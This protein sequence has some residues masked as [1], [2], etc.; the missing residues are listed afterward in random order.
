MLS[1]KAVAVLT[2]VI[3]AGVFA[4]SAGAS[5]VRITPVIKGAGTVYRVTGT[6]QNP[7]FTEM[8]TNT[9]T[10][11]RVT[12]NDC[13]QLVVSN[14]F[15]SQIQATI[16]AVPLG[17]PANHWFFVPGWFPGT[18]H[19]VTPENY[20]TFQAPFLG[21]QSF[22][23]LIIFDDVAAPGLLTFVT[24]S[25]SDV[26]DRTIT[27][28]MVWNEPVDAQCRIDGGTPVACTPDV[29]PFTLSEGDHTLDARA[30]DKSGNQSGFS[31]PHSFKI[32][33]TAINGGPSNG[34]TSGPNV[35][36][37]YSTVAGIAYDCAID[38]SGFF[39]C[40]SNPFS[41]FNG[42]TTGQ[43]T[44]QVR[45]K[46]GGYFDHVP[47]V[48]TW[49][50][51]ATPP[52]TS[53]ASGPPTLTKAKTAQ[54]HFNSSEGG[55]SF[56][57][58]LDGAAASACTSPLNLTGLGLGTHLLTVVATDQ[59]GNVDGTAATFSWTVDFAP[60]NTRLTKSPPANTKARK[61]AFKFN[62]T[63]PNSTFQC[64]LDKGAYKPC[65]SGKSYK[66][67]K[68]GKHTFRV[69]AIDKAGNVDAS[70]IVKTWR[71]T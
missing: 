64:K 69:R 30:F 18:C 26:A 62:S 57:C 56:Q 47:A 60:P 21:D 71:I 15:I 24:A 49:T 35:S 3:A 16:R 43:H 34:S 4:G 23:P 22:S 28:S 33:D 55:S 27:F 13:S 50:V 48:R 59:Y 53:V 38:G 66:N 40:G 42:L 41:A 8:C 11:D 9:N 25:Y 29:T 54:I 70:P 17:S 58:S 46:N 45:A 44:F 12:K 5:A 36:F 31:S 61:A 19:A 63:E 68:K 52:E 32:V 1:V 65:V 37:L 2:A 10:D 51:D 39:D 14:D 7:I 67:L 6:A 20:C